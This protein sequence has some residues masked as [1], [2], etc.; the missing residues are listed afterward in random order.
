MHRAG[1]PVFSQ[2]ANCQRCISKEETNSPGSV[3][4]VDFSKL[5]FLGP[6]LKKNFD[7]N[8]LVFSV[9]TEASNGNMSKSKCVSFFGLDFVTTAARLVSL[10]GADPNY[11]GC[12]RS[13]VAFGGCAG[14]V[15][16]HR[17]SENGDG[18]TTVI[19]PR[20]LFKYL[21]ALQID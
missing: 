2:A 18:F 3:P 19:Q 17:R 1:R 14:A 4:E 16:G 10:A 13:A 8:V 20:Q 5:L 9:F 12:D 7:E 6:Q 15:S 11:F 21:T